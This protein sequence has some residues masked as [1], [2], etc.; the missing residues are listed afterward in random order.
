MHNLLDKT[1][2]KSKLRTGNS[3]NRKFEHFPI[4]EVRLFFQIIEI[5]ESII[6]AKKWP[7][8]RQNELKIGLKTRNVT[9]IPLKFIT[10]PSN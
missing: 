3:N 2:I 9:K 1:G 7:F 6:F 4:I 5:I 10:F 8:S